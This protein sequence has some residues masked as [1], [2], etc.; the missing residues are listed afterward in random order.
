MIEEIKKERFLGVKSSNARNVIS[1]K[2]NRILWKQHSLVKA[3]QIPIKKFAQQQVQNTICLLQK[4]IN[5]T[6][7]NHDL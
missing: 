5:R 3:F 2:I 1:N 6:C 7:M 4:A